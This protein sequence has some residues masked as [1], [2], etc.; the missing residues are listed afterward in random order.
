MYFIFVRCAWKS[1]R[2]SLAPH[3]ECILDHIID[4]PSSFASSNL[5]SCSPCD[6][7]RTRSTLACYM[8]LSQIPSASLQPKMRSPTGQHSSQRSNGTS[9]DKG[10]INGVNSKIPQKKTLTFHCTGCLIGIHIMA[11]YTPHRTGSYSPLY[12]LN[13]QG[14]FSLLMFKVAL[15]TGFYRRPPIQALG[16]HF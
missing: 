10:S 9:C 16:T 12:T 7:N 6:Q 1:S 14:V 13:N 4:T 8:F 5:D 15:S 2:S 3:Y 11:Y